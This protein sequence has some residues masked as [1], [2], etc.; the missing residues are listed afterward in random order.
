MAEAQIVFALLP[1]DPLKGELHPANLSF[2]TK[3]KTFKLSGV[4][5]NLLVRVAS[6]P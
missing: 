3:K 1:P 5:F 2:I 4:D 6:P